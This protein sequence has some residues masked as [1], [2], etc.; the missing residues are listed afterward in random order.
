MLVTEND[1]DFRALCQ[2]AGLHPGLV[3]LP[4]VNRQRAHALLS[5]CVDHIEDEA[6]RTGETCAD[7]MLNR[8][9]EVDRAGIVVSTELPAQ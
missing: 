6:A 7:L 3:V 5:A 2:A 8:V 1:G 9:I 4:S